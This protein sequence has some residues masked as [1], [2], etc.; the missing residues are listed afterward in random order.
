MYKNVSRQSC[1]CVYIYILMLPLQIRHAR[2]NRGSCSEFC[3]WVLGSGLFVFLVATKE[4]GNGQKNS[5]TFSVGF[6]CV[7]TVKI[8]V[9]NL[10][11]ELD[12]TS[13]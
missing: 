13:C 10:H 12:N 9:S 6:V 11:H 8:P 3:V 4:T 2:Y 7:S 1:V 5:N